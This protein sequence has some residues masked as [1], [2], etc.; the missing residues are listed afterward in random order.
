MTTSRIRAIA[1]LQATPQASAP[2]ISSRVATDNGLPRLLA[3]STMPED[4]TGRQVGPLLLGSVDYIWSRFRERLNGLTEDEYLWNPV[5]AA[6]QCGRRPADGRLSALSRYRR[7]RRL[8]RSPG[9]YGTSA[10]NA[11]LDTRHK[12]SARGH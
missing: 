12:A 9:G 10:R 8:R 4:L 3:S 5:L 11:W 1:S 2:V 6:G 7:R